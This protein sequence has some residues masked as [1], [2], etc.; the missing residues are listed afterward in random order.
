MAKTTKTQIV[1]TYEEMDKFGFYDWTLISSKIVEPN[2]EDW[3]GCEYYEDCP[4]CNC[5][6]DVVV[7]ETYARPRWSKSGKRMVEET[8][9]VWMCVEHKK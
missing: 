8:T 3:G 6:Q 7:K 4:C 9:I 2:P 5:G 1:Y